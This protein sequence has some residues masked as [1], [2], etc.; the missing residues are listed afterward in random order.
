MLNLMVQEWVTKQI[1]PTLKIVQVNKLVEISIIF[2][3]Y[4]EQFIEDASGADLKE[5]NFMVGVIL[6]AKAIT[7]VIFNCFIG[8]IHY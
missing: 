8:S 5:D 7:Q 2:I 6:A 4:I 1:F 3:N